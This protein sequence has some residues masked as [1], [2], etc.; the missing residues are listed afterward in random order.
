MKTKEYNMENKF[1]PLDIDI[2]QKNIFSK[3][4]NAIE[5]NNEGVFIKTF[6]KNHFVIFTI[7]FLFFVVVTDIIL[8]FKYYIR[9]S[10]NIELPLSNNSNVFFSKI[11]I[12]E[13][14]FILI[15]FTILAV[16]FSFKSYY[17]IR[18]ISLFILTLCTFLNII[19][20]ITFYKFLQ[21]AI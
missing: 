12:L 17:G 19:F 7:S 5:Q 14:F 6:Y 1:L 16:F 9:L 4:K 3:F 13:I 20:L 10:S 18:Y 11:Y 8:I 2:Y 21:I 15:L